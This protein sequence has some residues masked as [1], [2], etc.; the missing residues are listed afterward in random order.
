[1]TMTGRLF[2]NTCLS[3]IMIIIDIQCLIL[4]LMN[5]LLNYLN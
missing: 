5:Y 4:L 2:N 1:M 3:S